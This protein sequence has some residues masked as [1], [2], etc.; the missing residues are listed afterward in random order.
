MNTRSIPVDDRA[1][2][3]AGAAASLIGTVIRVFGVVQGAWRRGADRLIA[4]RQHF[5][6][7]AVLRELSDHQLRDIGLTRAD[8]RREA[9]KPVWRL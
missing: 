2:V 7:R 6:D 5:R 8:V 9:D 3:L 4:W 1:V